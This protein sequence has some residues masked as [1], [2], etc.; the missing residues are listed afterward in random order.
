MTISPLMSALRVVLPVICMALISIP[1][2]AEAVTAQELNYRI[3]YK[4]SADSNGDPYNV[5]RIG[6]A[7]A[8]QTACESRHWRTVSVS[9]GGL[10]LIKS[11]GLYK[12]R[13]PHR[14]TLTTNADP[15]TAVQS[16]WKQL[17]Y[18]SGYTLD[19]WIRV[20]AWASTDWLLIAKDSRTPSLTLNDVKVG[21]DNFAVGVDADDFELTITDAH[22]LDH[23][24]GMSCLVTMPTGDAVIA[25]TGPGSPS[26]D[27]SYCKRIDDRGCHVTI[28]EDAGH[29]VGYVK[30]EGRLVWIV[31]P[32]ETSQRSVQTSVPIK[33]A[34]K[35]DPPP[36]R[37]WT[38]HEFRPVPG[39]HPVLLANS[40]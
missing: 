11:S 21:L 19:G 31:T 7:T 37:G 14:G 3:V 1:S 27:G 5:T 28:H 40:G 13:D 22:G 6:S 29:S 25:Y 4:A 15:S 16:E 33:Q 35:Q 12:L 34:S 10:D 24:C 20:N 2:N 26:I 18:R 39:S 30:P 38:L 23:K 36:D 17:I 8:C 9:V 32:P